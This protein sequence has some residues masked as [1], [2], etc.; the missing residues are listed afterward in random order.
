MPSE[1]VRNGHIELELAAP[2]INSGSNALPHRQRLSAAITGVL[3]H[4]ETQ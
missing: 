3:S 2:E 4:K 1:A